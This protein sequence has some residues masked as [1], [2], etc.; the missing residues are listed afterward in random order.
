MTRRQELITLFERNMKL[1]F[2]FL[3]DYKTYLEKT[4]YWNEPA[5][6][7][8]R[9]SHKQYFEELR[10]TSSV[11][12]S[13]AQYNAIKTVEIQSDLIEK[14]ITGLNQQYESM[15]SIYE[16]LKRKVEQSSN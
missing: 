8:S 3:N 9:W 16:D 7:D 13:D 5:F 4:S 10:K 2:Q 15:T 6:F 14:Y 12:Y 1:I 11:E